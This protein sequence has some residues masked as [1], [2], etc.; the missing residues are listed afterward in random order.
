M[1]YESVQRCY[2]PYLTMYVIDLMI[3]I[4]SIDQCMQRHCGDCRCTFM[5]GAYAGRRSTQG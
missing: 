1:L 3:H 4:Y 5:I 2:K